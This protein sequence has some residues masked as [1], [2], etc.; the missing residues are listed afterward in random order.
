MKLNAKNERLKRNYRTFLKE[1]DGKAEGT[2]DQI[3]KAIERYEAFTVKADFATFDQ[4]K[5]V[6]FKDQMA[7][8]QLA[9]AT[10][11]STVKALKR[12]FGWL[13]HQPGFRSRIRQT[14]IEYLNLAD[15]DIRAAKS[16]AD[17]PVPSLEQ[18]Q[19]VFAKMPSKTPIEQRNKAIFALLSLTG[20]RDGA[21]ITLKLK[22]F[23]EVERRILQNPNEVATKNAKRIDSFLIDIV[24]EMSATLVSWKRF[25]IEDQLF[26][27]TDPLF[28]KTA[29]GHDA[30]DCFVA[31]GLSREH[32]STAQ[33]V[34]D[35]V[36]AGF[37]SAGLPSFFPH[38]FRHMLVQQAYRLCRTPEEFKAWSQ[39][40]GHQ[41][42]LTTLMS[43]GRLDL[44][45]QR[46]VLQSVNKD[47]SDEHSPL[48]K[49]DLAELVAQLQ[50]G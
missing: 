16:P 28:P 18:V 25:L 6:R 49:K 32:W 20:I 43:Y 44:H 33:P 37:E 8:Q 34:R 9:K 39:N 23:N 31:E 5:A 45:R 19:R 4:R 7:D 29:M 41:E 24:P 11:L 1:A 26:T 38:S 12:F 3:M 2:I 46:E 42:V 14:D 40:F 50:S 35:I 10:I 21:L 27:P 15:R 17:R 47:R 22:H 13:S 36:R 48:T 30:N